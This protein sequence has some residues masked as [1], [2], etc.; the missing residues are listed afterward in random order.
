MFLKACVSRICDWS[1]ENRITA[2]NW[3]MFTGLDLSLSI[4][5]SLVGPSKADLAGEP[6]PRFQSHKLNPNLIMSS[7]AVCK[8]DVKLSI[9]S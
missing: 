2:F 3:N 5:L 1:L 8:L 9:F 7:C 4:L 6:K